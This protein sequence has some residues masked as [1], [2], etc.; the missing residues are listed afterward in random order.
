M[1]AR[2][3]KL[4]INSV[5]LVASATN[6]EVV[7][8]VR[9]LLSEEGISTCLQVVLPGCKSARFLSWRNFIISID[10]L[11]SK[12]LAGSKVP[13]IC[14]NAPFCKSIGMEDFVSSSTEFLNMIDY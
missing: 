7:S 2:S 9:N 5:A 14:K 4:P 12:L 6:E 11:L 3:A 1:L 10:H 8:I 13:T